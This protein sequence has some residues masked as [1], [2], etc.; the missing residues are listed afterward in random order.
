MA[1][2][3]KWL[4]FPDQSAR[5]LV[6]IPKDRKPVI[7]LKVNE[8]APGAAV[9]AAAETAGFIRKDG[10]SVAYWPR[11]KD[12]KTVTTT[13]LA[14]TF[15][16]AGIVTEM[17][18]LSAEVFAQKPWRWDA[19]TQRPAQPLKPEEPLEEIGTNFRGEL[20]LRSSAGRFYRIIDGQGERQFVEETA[21]DR[22]TLFLRA[23]TRQ[24]VA[25]IAQGL[26]NT[27]DKAPIGKDILERFSGMML[28]AGPAGP[29]KIDAAEA[30]GFLASELVVQIGKSIRPGKD[31]RATFDNACRISERSKAS[32]LFGLSDRGFV[33]NPAIATAIHRAL[34]NLDGLRPDIQGLPEAR[35]MLS[36]TSRVA[37]GQKADVQVLDLTGTPT[38]HLSDVVMNTLAAREPEGHS[39]FVVRGTPD[40]ESIDRLREDVGR[41]F[42]LES[43]AT[44]DSQIHS[45]RLDGETLTIL[46]VG[47]QRR[48]VA[49]SLP[50]AARR[51]SH[52]Q[53][54]SELWTWSSEVLRS[55]GRIA[56]WEATASRNDLRAEAEAEREA[57]ARQVPY[58]ALSQVKPAFTM[59]PMALE[60]A[61]MKAL[62]R[63]AA[64]AEA[65]GGVDI[66][67]ANDL[68]IEPEALGDILTAEQVD[69]LALHISAQARN[70]GFL[71]SDQT[72]VGKGRA[73]AA[74]ARRHIRNGGRVIYFT[75]S[76]NINIPDVWRDFK[77][78]GAD[79]EARPYLLATNA[80][81]FSN[82]GDIVAKAQS[83][84][85][86]NRMLD[87]REFP[88]D[89]NVVLT[90][91]TMFMKEE[92]GNA[93]LWLA[94]VLSD[95]NTMVILDEAHNALNR[96]SNMGRTLRR[97]LGAA[98][99]GNVIFAT[100]TPM[101]DPKGADL[102]SA[103]LPADVDAEDIVGH[104]ASG[105][106]L[107]Q[108]T[109][110][111]MLA[112][113][114][115]MIRRDHDLSAI[116]FEIRYPSNEQVAQN[117]QYMD[118]LAPVVENM[119]LASFEVSQFMGQ[120][121]NEAL[122]RM[123]RRGVQP[124]IATARVN[125]MNQYSL[126]FGS[127]LLNL[128]R[129]YMNA[130]KYKQ[131]AQEAINEL[132]EGRKPLITFHSTNAGLL[133]ESI[134]TDEGEMLSQEEI[135]ALPPLTLR[136]Q[137]NRLC[138]RLYRVKQN[139]VWQD[140]RE[141]WPE[142]RE[143]SERI[144]ALVERLPQDLPVSPID[145]LIETLEIEGY[146][147]GELSG[148]DLAYRD[149]QII[150]RTDT[151]R[152]ATIDAFNGGSVDVLV[153]N[154]AGATGGSYHASPD[155]ADQRP[156]TMVE[157]ETPP[158]IK[159]YVQSQGRGN[160]YGQVAR[161]RVV[162]VVT[163]LAPE[164]RILA[165]R[166]RKLRLLG[167][168]VDGNRSHPLLLD[169]VPD[170]INQVGDKAAERVLRADPTLARRMG[171][172]DLVEG[173]GEDV[174][175]EVDT[176]AGEVHSLANKILARS[177]LLPPDAQQDLFERV[178]LE[179]EAIIEELDSRNS[180]PLRPKML[181]GEIRVLGS[182]LFEGQERLENDMES[183]AFTKPLYMLTAEHVFTETAMSGERIRDMIDRAVIE[184]G[185]DG[186]QRYADS[187]TQSKPNIL[188]AFLNDGVSYEAAIANPDLQ[189]RTF[190]ITN[191]RL[192]RLIW[193]L[194]N[195]KPGVQMTFPDGERNMYER[196]TVVRLQSPQRWHMQMASA[197]K[198]HLVAPGD[199]EAEIMTLSRFLSM[200]DEDL[201]FLPGFAHG[202][203]DQ[204][205]LEFEESS[206]FT[207]RLP[208]QILTGNHLLAMA[209]A[210]NNKLGSM[211]L[212]RSDNGIE[213]GVVVSPSKHNLRNLPCILPNAETA[214]RFLLADATN[215][216]LSIHFG[217]PAALN[218]TVSI[219]R[220]GPDK[221]RFKVKPF[222]I[223]GSEFWREKPLL[224]R[225]ATGTA[226]PDRP[227]EKVSKLIERVVTVTDEG[228]ALLAAL[229]QA[230]IPFQT[231]GLNRD[232]VNELSGAVLAAFRDDQ[233]A[234]PTDEAV[235]EMAPAD[236]VATT[237]EEEAV[238]ENAEPQQ[239]PAIVEENAFDGDWASGF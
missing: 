230:Q 16:A 158:D 189:S 223:S 193:L 132:A 93:E 122:V 105:K 207:R 43:V 163:G 78:V 45:S 6:I 74:M 154:S 65:L 13:Q 53:S 1:K 171:F 208:V 33:P 222:N 199:S 38:D 117:R 131:V 27:L 11:S 50:E 49:P 239:A 128:T 51:V 57:N 224:W 159:K 79:K 150:K 64:D 84:A 111:T 99:P 141:L 229:Q 67:I 20:V 63:A 198:I 152:R 88:A 205:L 140:A 31:I 226:V 47:R 162:S 143:M 212:Y 90:T 206:R 103:L 146:R 120:V 177:I 115:V 157:M 35:S 176:T 123:L 148:R 75:E 112:E 136:D 42:S 164:M 41:R 113:D 138:S 194:E 161:P 236:E 87:S 145:A 14:E 97:G 3:I 100:A 37:A 137:I 52:I 170:L 156:R 109:F 70:R 4:A 119:L 9:M 21:S 22:P 186:F 175:G 221:I 102:Y 12:G 116:E 126:G 218:Y 234:A 23:I 166:N 235:V 129:I 106:E 191:S 18:H 44:I 34:G 24:D 125:Q 238:V 71:E 110:T 178:T 133:Y 30:A 173:M 160:R 142:I 183:S 184:T 91:Y 107:A 197:Y 196:R 96:S 147:V 55:R 76:A 169:N 54:F 61:T 73:L 26:M 25:L 213:R 121:Q 66:M 201:R 39:Y 130:L 168:S 89:A 217:D 28:E 2:T 134:R 237:I 62:R 80:E 46:G 36:I 10:T 200:R 188:Q 204:M 165:Q 29:S 202:M 174:E 32:G 180:N 190:K 101:S 82:S 7:A 86:R 214:T 77:N 124:E 185:A 179:F 155:F 19:L 92:D 151:D 60:A 85:M 48:E 135:A 203:D 216:N 219:K 215:Q 108:E 5:L 144:E 228:A 69:A 167:A 72:G 192:D 149:G 104:L 187:L 83:S 233:P 181:N 227:V 139:D 58:Q 209:T 127:P 210:R 68:G 182:S 17:V 114:G 56:E 232:L 231:D 94:E 81:I 220:I 98:T 172:E 195:I 95:P 15:A 118:L 225:L 211:S 59:I 8:G 153:F 40:V